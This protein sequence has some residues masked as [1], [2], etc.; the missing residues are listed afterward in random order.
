MFFQG[1]NIFLKFTY[2]FIFYCKAFH[3]VFVFAIYLAAFCLFLFPYYQ[4]G[5]PFVLIIS[6]SHLLAI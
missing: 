6:P 4:W 5:D 1:L 3:F 2:I